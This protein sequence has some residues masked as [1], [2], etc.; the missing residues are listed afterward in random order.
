MIIQILTPSLEGFPADI[1]IK[2]LV[3]H[4][5]QR[6]HWFDHPEV[7]KDNFLQLLQIVATPSPVPPLLLQ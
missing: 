2:W 3:G 6:M 4:T 7:H 1:S 5:K